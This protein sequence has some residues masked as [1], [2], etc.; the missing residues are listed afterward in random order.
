MQLSI[1]APLP[2]FICILP[3]SVPW[4]EKEWAAAYVNYD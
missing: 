3:L 2:P 4:R 1:I